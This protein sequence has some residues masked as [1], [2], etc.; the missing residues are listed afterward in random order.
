MVDKKMD[1]VP[2]LLDPSVL[3]RKEKQTENEEDSGYGEWNTQHR[4]GREFSRMMVRGSHS[5]S[6]V[7]QMRDPDVAPRESLRQSLMYT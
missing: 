2:C 1:S 6:C 4:K 3:H 5:D 7:H